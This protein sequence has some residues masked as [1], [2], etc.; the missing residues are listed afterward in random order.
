MQVK[1]LLEYSSESQTC[2]IQQS[3]QTRQQRCTGLLAR[4][5]CGINTEE[6]G[7]QRAL[8]MIIREIATQSTNL[9]KP[10][11]IRKESEFACT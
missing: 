3:D 5:V 4:K 2:N 11:E 6:T 8:L 9:C 10:M 1:E 7:L